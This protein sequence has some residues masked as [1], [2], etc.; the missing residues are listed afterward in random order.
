MS[1]KLREENKN[2]RKENDKLR[3]EV[4]EIRQMLHDEK[5]RSRQEQLAS[6]N[7]VPQQHRPNEANTTPQNNDQPEK[8]KY[9]PGFNSTLSGY[10]NNPTYSY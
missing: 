1:N 8:P 10:N 2:L 4:L 9:F 5:N 3:D 6:T 7:Y